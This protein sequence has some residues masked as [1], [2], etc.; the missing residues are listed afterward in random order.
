[1]LTI[2]KGYPEW[3]ANIR[4]RS[5]WSAEVILMHW[6]HAGPAYAIRKRYWWLAESIHIANGKV[7]TRI[8]PGVNDPMDKPPLHAYMFNQGTKAKEEPMS[9]RSKGIT[10]DLLILRYWLQRWSRV[11]CTLTA[12]DLGWAN[13][14]RIM[15]S[16]AIKHNLI[17][18][19]YGPVVVAWCEAQSDC[20]DDRS[21]QGSWC[22]PSHAE[23]RQ[24]LK[25]LAHCS[26]SL[27]S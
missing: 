9:L 24:H 10:M 27:K 20:N 7:F 4:K 6:H 16:F 11:T 8:S 1:M 2:E 25:D 15:M 26:S 19:P 3:S 12:I 23:P 5:W 21:H 17:C 13:G 22:Q 14:N 18:K